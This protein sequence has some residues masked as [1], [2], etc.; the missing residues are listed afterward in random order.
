MLAT[1]AR[2]VVDV[3]EGVVKGVLVTEGLL[4]TFILVFAVTITCVR[5]TSPQLSGGV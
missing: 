5:P 3:P 1:A 4:K 2:V